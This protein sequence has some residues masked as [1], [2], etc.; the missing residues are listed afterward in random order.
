M[1]EPNPKRAYLEIAL[2]F[3]RLGFLSY[4][5]PA[6]L[7]VMQ[8]ELQEK[9]K[10]LTAKRFTEGLS[11][12]NVLPGAGAT[13]LGIFLGYVRGGWWGGLLAGLCFV[14]PAFLIMMLL[15][16]AYTRFGSSALLRDIL[17]G[18][19]PVVLAIFLVAVYRLGRSA[20]TNVLP[21]AIA[22]AAAGAAILS[23]I[24]IA[25]ILLLAAALGL[26]LF[27]SKRVGIIIAIA[28]VAIN[29]GLPAALSY[30]NQTTNIVPTHSILDV[31]AFFL[32]V[33]AL[34]F[35]GGLSMLAFVQDQVVN[36]FHW[37]SPQEFVDGLALGQLTPGPILMVAAYVGFKISGLAG[38]VVA[39][40]AI[41]LSSFLLMLTLLPVFD[42]VRKLRWMKATMRGVGPAVIGVLTV[43]LVEL[44][45]HAVH[46]AFGIGIFVAAVSVAMAWRIGPF[47]LMLGGGLLGVLRGRL[48]W[49]LSGKFG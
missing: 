14:L 6:I 37:L 5:G 3:L 40:A 12:V 39:A 19:S 16:L 4:G 29:L 21:L 18:L 2:T 13:Q 22:I 11:L 23:P 48:T 38:A 31:G 49:I 41:F 7:G 32:K 45:P 30:L 24:G 47:K 42:R 27:Y 17:Y 15:T 33:G 25:S 26:T 44:A 20:I 10:W 46:D 36:Q 1:T 28:I 34:T 9:R 43:S 8:A 35:G